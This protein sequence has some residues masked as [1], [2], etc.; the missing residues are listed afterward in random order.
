MVFHML[1]TSAVL[2]RFHMLD[3]LGR[4]EVLDKL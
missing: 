4:S 1:D 3:M 2:G